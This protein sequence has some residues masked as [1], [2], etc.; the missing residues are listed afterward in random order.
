MKHP[1][2]SSAS[3]R[4]TST[5]IE[6]PGT[7]GVALA[8][9]LDSPP[10]PRAYPVLTHCFTYGKDIF[11]AARIAERLVAHGI[12][13]LHF[14]FTGT[15]SSDGEFANTNFS[16]NVD[17]LLAA[18]NFLRERYAGPLSLS[19]TASAAARCSRPRHEFLR[20]GPPLQ[21]ARPRLLRTWS[22]GSRTTST[23]GARNQRHAS[24][25]TRRDHG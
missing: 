2:K 3:V 23:R 14:D 24:T 20:S 17:D 18:V 25:R 9:R 13:V 12:A 4:K 16:S 10:A 19:A 11:A 8:A 15:G 1:I 22:A 7:T 5:K 21:S 6:F